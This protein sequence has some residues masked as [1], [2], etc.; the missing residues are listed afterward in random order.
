MAAA[1]RKVSLP[2]SLVVQHCHSRVY[3]VSPMYPVSHSFLVS[4]YQW[5]IFYELSVGNTAERKAGPAFK[6]LTVQWGSKLKTRLIQ[7]S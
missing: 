3:F 1:A 7:S 6:G 2:F 5:N 4:K